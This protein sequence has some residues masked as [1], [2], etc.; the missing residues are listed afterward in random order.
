MARAPRWSSKG[1]TCSARFICTPLPQIALDGV[2]HQQ[3][4]AVHPAQG[5]K[6]LVA[7]AVTGTVLKVQ[8]VK[9]CPHGLGA[10]TQHLVGVV[11]GGKVEH[12]GGGLRRGVR[13]KGSAPGKPG[14][15]IQRKAG[16]AR[17]GHAAQNAYHAPGQVGL[18]QI[19]GTLRRKGAG[20]TDAEPPAPGLLFGFGFGALLLGKAGLHILLAGVCHKALDI[21]PHARPAVG[22]PAL[23][24]A[25]VPQLT[26]V[27]LPPQQPQGF[28]AA[29]F[30]QRIHQ[31]GGVIAEQLGIRR[32]LQMLTQLRPHLVLDGLRLIVGGTVLVCVHVKTSFGHKVSTLILRRWT[33]KNQCVLFGSQSVLSR[34][35]YTQRK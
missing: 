25:S 4:R 11:L 5:G 27:Q 32:V 29:V 23:H 2:E 14:A 17:S 3:R 34:T 20:G 22:I 19:G 6:L 18:H 21:L 26:A 33:R 15:H 9:V 10:G 7:H 35:R 24:P 8:P 31:R 28:L 1:R 12:G 13:R 16:L 30:V